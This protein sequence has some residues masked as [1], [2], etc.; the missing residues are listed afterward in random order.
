MFHGYK[1][2]RTDSNLFY[3][4]YIFCLRIRSRILSAAAPRK[5]SASGPLSA[6]QPLLRLRPRQFRF[7]SFFRSTAPILFP[8][9]TVPLPS[10]FRSTAPLSFPPK[11]VPL[12]VLFRTTALIPL[13]VSF[14]CS[15]PVPFPFRFRSSFR[16]P[17]P[18]RLPPQPL[19]TPSAASHA[20]GS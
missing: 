20:L 8:P 19:A 6:L 10:Y 7:R 11:T 16:H 17:A 9:K 4:L 12:P 3:S 5:T 2:S 13:P 18:F 15:V 14:R 1:I